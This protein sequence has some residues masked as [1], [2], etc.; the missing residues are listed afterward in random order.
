MRPSCLAD[1][2]LVAPGR[3][4]QVTGIFPNIQEEPNPGYLLEVLRSMCRARPSPAAIDVARAYF[5]YRQFMREPNEEIDQ[6]IELGISTAD[7]LLHYIEK[8]LLR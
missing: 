7:T 8:Y 3:P 1:T 5:E 4:S 6:M 2:A